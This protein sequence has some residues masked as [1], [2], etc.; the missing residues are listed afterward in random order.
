[1]TPATMA[2]M[3]PDGRRLGAHL[4]LGDGMVKAADRAAEIGANAL[5]IFGDNP[6]AWKRRAEP[7]AEQ[8]A[9]RERLAEL[10][11]APLVVHA[12][13]LINLAGPDP[14]FF[15]RSIG[16]LAAELRD[17]PGLG[18]RHV[19]VHIGSHRGNGLETGIERLADGIVRTL[20]R[21]AEGAEE[22][23]TG[24]PAQSPTLLLENS[25]G[26]GW[27]LGVSVLELAQI[28]E[29][30]DGRG[31]SR[32]RLGFCLD[33]AHAWGAGIDLSDPLAID[34]LLEEFQRRIGLDRLAVI[35]LND[36]KSA[37]GSRIDRHE[38]VGA[39]QIGETGMA[40]ILRHPL[41][42]HVAYI[43]ETPGMDEGYDAINIARAVAL[44]RGEPLAPL[45]PGALTLRGSR[46]RSAGLAA[47][48]AADE[49]VDLDA[50]NGQ[51]GSPVG[52]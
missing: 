45:P 31:V 9:F 52:Q 22:D 35:H 43:L 17:A 41:L 8:A 38:H 11:I 34:T 7:A 44:A 46:S 2:R 12:S 49:V 26:G 3:L 40:H 48:A 23:G 10:G 47:P 36:S 42:A 37:L 39:G 1:M 28:A 13:Y 6:T 4:P 20:E 27:G 29:A 14:D 25:S 18:A 15:D 50:A 32:D 16:L 19:N 51:A 33:T 5:Q 21:A 24:E 30:I